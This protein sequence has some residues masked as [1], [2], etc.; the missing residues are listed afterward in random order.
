VSTEANIQRMADR[1]AANAALCKLALA[2]Y[3][4]LPR[5]VRKAR[6]RAAK[7]AGGAR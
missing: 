2:D 7:A 6:V 5:K 3:L 4:A 1:Q